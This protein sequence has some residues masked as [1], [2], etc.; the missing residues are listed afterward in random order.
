V[1]I[2]HPGD[3]YKEGV[4]YCALKTYVCG[5][6][7]HNQYETEENAQSNNKQGANLLDEVVY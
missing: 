4:Q 5:D 1:P 2:Y 3:L 6:Q 7:S